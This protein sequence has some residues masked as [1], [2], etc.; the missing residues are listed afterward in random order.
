M[1][2]LGGLVGLGAHGLLRRFGASETFDRV[3]RV[4][5][6]TLMLLF[7]ALRF[8]VLKVQY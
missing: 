8:M 7:V 4:V 6:L 1:N 2:T 3:V 5:L